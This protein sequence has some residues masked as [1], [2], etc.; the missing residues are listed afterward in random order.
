MKQLR[1]IKKQKGG[2]DAQG[3]VAV[4]GQGGGHKQ[5][6]RLVDFRRKKTIPGKVV[7][8]EYD[9]NRTCEIALVQYADGDKLYILRPE[10]L[11]IGDSVKV[12]PN[13]E[14]R[15][16]NALPLMNIPVGTIV[17]NV[18]ITPG[19]G[20]QIARGAGAAVMVAA[21]EEK[22]VHLRMPSGEI[23]RVPHMAM[24]TVG[25]VGNLSH[26]DEVIGKAGTKRHMGIRPT[27]RGV[28]QDPRSHP[29][30]GGEGR[31]GIG[32]ATPKTYAG[33]PAVGKRRKP[34][35]Y[36]NKYIVQRRKK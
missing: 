17:H 26:K 5:F 27:V 33:R 30:G 32:M 19:K 14:I 6:I 31:S 35:K 2:R 16:G 1:V 9:P 24:A 29:H 10:G 25:Q 13:V 12:G 36:S 18:E 4:R 20:G 21:R 23:R 28:A 15:V 8:I 22:Y 3:R 7:A 34:K 11:N